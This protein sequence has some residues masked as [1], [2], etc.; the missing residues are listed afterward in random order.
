MVASV[1]RMRSL[2]VVMRA[3]NQTD[4]PDRT[5]LSAYWTPMDTYPPGT[6]P[7]PARLWPTPRVAR[8]PRL[9]PGPG[10][11]GCFGRNKVTACL[12]P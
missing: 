2:V 3:V 1:A 6:G 4:G 11:A 10:G 8:P 7:D 5:S 9:P 12:M